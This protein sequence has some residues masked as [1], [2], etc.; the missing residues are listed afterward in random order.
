MAA[1]AQITADEFVAACRAYLEAHGSSGSSQHSS[2]VIAPASDL[3]S[4]LYSRGWNLNE[5]KSHFGLHFTYL[6]RSL[7]IQV[8]LNAVDKLHNASADSSLDEDWVPEQQGEDEVT[9]ESV[10]AQPPASGPLPD[11]DSLAVNADPSASKDGGPAPILAM[12]HQSICYSTTWKV[13]TF[14]FS[15]SR[16]DGTPLTLN[17]VIRS[18]IVQHEL[19]PLVERAGNGGQHPQFESQEAEGS[20]TPAVPATAVTEKDDSPDLPATFAPIST[21][22][23]PVTGLP[24]LYLHPCETATWLQTLLT[25]QV[26]QRE[27]RTALQRTSSSNSGINVNASTPTHTD[28][29]EDEIPD[30]DATPTG[31]PTPAV[32]PN[33]ASLTS[34]MET[35]VA[36]VASAIEMRL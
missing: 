21:C 25:P 17:Q 2:Q 35:F 9:A 4:R 7:P 12:M 3:S 18:S 31:S 27:A 23:H 29:K 22:D 14:Y 19:D 1:S 26:A 6:E 36:L 16:S 33:S 11:L 34:Y 15:A 28:F 13:P 32:P 10:R 5:S 30:G 24:V 20:A 8:H